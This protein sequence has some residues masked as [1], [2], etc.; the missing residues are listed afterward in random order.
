M[1]R[2]KEEI[3]GKVFGKWVAVSYAG[4]F[5]WNCR[6]EC[7]F[8]KPVYTHMLKNGRSRMCYRC[9]MIGRRKHGM[10]GTGMYKL[11]AGIKKRC[12]DKGSHAYPLYGGRGIVMCDRWLNSPE[13]FAA[14]MGPRPQGMTI[15]RID[16]NG[17]YSPGNCKWA[18]ALEQAQ[19]K[20]NNRKIA[21]G[22][23]VACLPEWAR[24]YRVCPNRLRHRVVK[25]GHALVEAVASI[26]A[27]SSLGGEDT[28]RW[29]FNRSSLTAERLRELLD[30]DPE[31]GRF[32][33]SGRVV[34]QS[35]NASGHLRVFVA[36]QRYMS[37]RLAWL[38]MTGRWPTMMVHHADGNP[39][40]NAWRNLREVSRPENAL[41]HSRRRAA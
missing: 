8:E 35:P 10:S 3:A 23:E 38:Y 22:G 27:Q 15:E 37:H 5:R 40:N 19:N 21:H 26:K 32:V 31:T 25:H 13:A 1:G 2:P 28:S 14:D 39:A 33:R 36:G 11:Y 6:C 16:V 18:S 7:G 30:Y 9:S 34:G 41:G 24:R 4:R 17:D 12:Y 20:R 29:D